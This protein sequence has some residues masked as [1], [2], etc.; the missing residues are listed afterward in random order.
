MSN[1]D[2]LIDE[3]Y[4][5]NLLGHLK[6]AADILG[7]GADVARHEYTMA[8]T[9]TGG[10]PFTAVSID[11]AR[12]LIDVGA[13]AGS[14]PKFAQLRAYFGRDGRLQSDRRPTGR[15]E[16]HDGAGAQGAD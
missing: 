9:R 12:A 15:G 4:C 6:P 7:S 13:V 2:S 3:V 10:D 16:A 8:Q 11:P 5:T 14:R 1:H